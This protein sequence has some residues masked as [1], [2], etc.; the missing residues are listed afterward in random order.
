MPASA[1]PAVRPALRCRLVR[2]PLPAVAVPVLDPAQ[3]QVVTHPGG[4]LLVLA[5][6]GTGKTTC[7]VEAVV[8]R[9]RDRG[10][11][12]AQVLVLTFSSK[13]A[14]ELRS[15]IA[16]RLGRTTREP[17]ALTFHSYAFGLVR[18][19]ALRAGLPVPRL[20]S[21]AEH[22]LEIRRLL[23]GEAEDGGRAWPA[24]LRPALRTRG[25]AEEL[26][27]LLLRATERGLDEDELS[28]LAE[29]CQRDDTISNEESYAD[30]CEN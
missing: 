8:H 4:P 17:L 18:Q 19:E 21:G 5:G 12:P 13:A 7:L 16:A 22:D 20:L 15:R 11:D 24:R 28:E 27:D 3:R 30:D 1:T 25:F 10:V 6:P 14:G 23:V 2:R 29:A 9:V 26:R